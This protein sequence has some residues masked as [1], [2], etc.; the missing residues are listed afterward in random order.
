MACASAEGTSCTAEPGTVTA[1]LACDARKERCL[2]CM[3]TGLTRPAFVLRTILEPNGEPGTADKAVIRVWPDAASA[4]LRFFRLDPDILVTLW[5]DA[6]RQWG[7]DVVA[8]DIRPGDV[9]WA[10]GSVSGGLGDCRLLVLRRAEIA[11]RVGMSRDGDFP[12]PYGSRE[13]ET[14]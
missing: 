14:R 11:R 1:C 2:R 7:W 12:S 3:G 8:D 6:G 10:A 5:T 4:G 9:H 13:T